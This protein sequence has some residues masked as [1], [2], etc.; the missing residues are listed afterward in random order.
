MHLMWCTDW[1]LRP[2][3]TFGCPSKLQLIPVAKI[4]SAEGI[5]FAGLTLQTLK[6]ALT[7]WTRMPDGLCGESLHLY[8]SY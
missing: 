3:F 2:A 5:W 7:S 6:L 4:L 8:A 1:L